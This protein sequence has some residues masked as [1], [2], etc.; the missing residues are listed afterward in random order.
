MKLRS[1][2][3]HALA[4]LCL[5]TLALPADARDER[6]RDDLVIGVSQVPSSLHPGIDAEAIKNYVLGFA[7]RPVTAFDPEWKNSCLL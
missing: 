3:L 1:A 6:A 2:V 5:A 7:I 4:V